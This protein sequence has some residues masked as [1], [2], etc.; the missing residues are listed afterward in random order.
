MT[1]FYTAAEAAEIAKTARPVIDAAC[2]SGALFAVDRKPA[3]TRRSWV[4]AE[5]DLE[6]W[7]RRGRP[8][9]PEVAA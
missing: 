9:V 3:S 5:S 6:D 4:I 8:A 1:A 7:H 2:A